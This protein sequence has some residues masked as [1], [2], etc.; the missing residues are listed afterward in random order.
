MMEVMMD[1]NFTRVQFDA[2]YAQAAKMPSRADL[3]SI[4][5]AARMLGCSIRTLRYR[6]KQNEMPPRHRRGRTL[7]YRRADIAKMARRA[8]G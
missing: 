2:L 7:F 6:Q 8:G 1:I 4:K 3:V 5:E